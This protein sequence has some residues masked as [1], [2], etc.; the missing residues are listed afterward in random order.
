MLLAGSALIASMI[1]Y[2][3]QRD[4]QLPLLFEQLLEVESAAQ[5][6]EVE[7]R[8]WSLWLATDDTR[9]DF[10]MQ[11]ILASMDSGDLEVALEVSTDLVEYAPDF[12]EGWN[13]RATIYYLMGNYNASV[14]DIQQ[15]LIL[16]PRHFGA[17][18]GLGLI[19]FRQGNLS[20]ALEA[21][22]QVVLITPQSPNA[23]RSVEQ[24]QKQLGDE[25]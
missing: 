13:K 9:A 14:Q 11:R 15:T 12:A 7:A 10:L 25:I 18:S 23:K 24:V 1:L 3:D 22:E 5:A 21:F 4:S 2:A 19:F 8:I 6:R 16:E 20:A 17:I